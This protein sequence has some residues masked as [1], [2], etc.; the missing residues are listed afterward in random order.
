MPRY[1]TRQYD[2]P[3]LRKNPSSTF[4]S[5][6]VWDTELNQIADSKDG[7]IAV[8]SSITGEI[9][10]ILA[11]ERTGELNADAVQ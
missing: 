3:Q 1:E 8:Y 11:N 10:C 7:L 4:S 5:Y 6:C 9:A 2:N